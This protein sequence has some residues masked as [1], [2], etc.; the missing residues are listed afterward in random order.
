MCCRENACIFIIARACS[1][2]H[3]DKGTPDKHKIVLTGE[4]HNV[5]CACV[6]LVHFLCS[7]YICILSPQPDLKPGDVIIVIRE[8]EHSVFT[9]DEHNNLRTHMSI[10]ITEAL[11]GFT[12]C[13]LT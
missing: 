10:S 5:V 9:R 7:E 12:V 8:A 3:V 11:C 2:V 1:Q 4:G 13:N 6:V